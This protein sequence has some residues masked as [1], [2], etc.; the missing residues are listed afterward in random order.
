MDKLEHTSLTEQNIDAYHKLY[1]EAVDLFIHHADDEENPS[2]IGSLAQLH[3][4]VSQEKADELGQQFLTARVSIALDGP[5]APCAADC[6]SSSAQKMAPERPHPEA[7]QSGGV[8][9][10]MAAAFTKPI[11]KLMHVSREYAKPK[12]SRLLDMARLVL[13]SDPLIPPPA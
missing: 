12:V 13:A 3:T 4:K 2:V 11:D 1:N 7:P 6:S 10:K 9:H 5:F 8:A